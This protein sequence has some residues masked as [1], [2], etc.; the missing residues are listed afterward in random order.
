VGAR[1]D[2]ARADVVAARKGLA[3]E[4]DRLEAAGRAAIDIPARLRREP[5]KVVGAAAGAAFLVAGGP[6]RLL[7]RLT[8]RKGGKGGVDTASIIPEAIQRGLGKR[9]ADGEKT[10]KQLEKDFAKYLES[11]GGKETGAALAIGGTAA[12]LISNVLKPVTQRAGKRLAEELFDA[13]RETSRESLRKVRA[14]R[15]ASAKDRDR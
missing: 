2:A 14:D 3:D 10:K 9:G 12:Q 15:N 6:G 4:V 5:A 7:R 13:D 11:R 1:T 8:G